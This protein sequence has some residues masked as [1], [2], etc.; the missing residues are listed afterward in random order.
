MDKIPAFCMF[1]CSYS[2]IHKQCMKSNVNHYVAECMIEKNIVEKSIS[3][4]HTFAHHYCL[5]VGWL[6]RESCFN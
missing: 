2:N 1:E 3:S 6:A 4:V 5:T